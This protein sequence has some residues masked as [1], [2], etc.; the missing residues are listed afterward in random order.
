MIR[1][2]KIII[3]RGHHLLCAPRFIGEGYSEDFILRMGEV[4]TKLGLPNYCNKNMKNTYVDE[5]KDIYVEEY[6][7][8]YVDKD[9]T[10]YADTHID[11]YKDICAD[12]YLDE[13]KDTYEDTY[14]EIYRVKIICGS[15]YV[16]E[17]CP[18][19]LPDGGCELS[20]QD[21]Y[22]K[23]KKAIMAAGL[24]ENME[25]SVEEI[26]QAISKFSREDFVNICSGC[27]WFHICEKFE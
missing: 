11:E 19:K 15:D 25:Y 18:N 23:D 4:V 24:I 21:V 10:I 6:K 12:I 20:T 13:Y 17:K 22:N 1:M 7:D 2:E 16:C 9:K 27:R 8:T 14:K 3:L 26:R 5:Y